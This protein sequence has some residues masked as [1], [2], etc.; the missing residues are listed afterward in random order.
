[1]LSGCSW[2]AVSALCSSSCPLLRTLDVQ[3]VEGLKD[4]QMRDLLSPPTDNRPGEWPGLG[5][6]LA[7]HTKA[8]EP[9]C[10]TGSGFNHGPYLACVLEPP[11]ASALLQR[12]QT[13]PGRCVRSALGTEGL[14][15][16]RGSRAHP[17]G[18]LLTHP[19]ASL[20][21]CSP[22]ASGPREH[23]GQC[24][25]TGSHR[26]VQGSSLPGWHPLKP[27]VTQGR[28]AASAPVAPV[29]PVGIVGA[30]YVFC[31]LSLEV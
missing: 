9:S 5:R 14:R 27:M 16:G 7:G 29:L 28:G 15:G 17:L 21:T 26:R 25:R 18:G 1:M 20:L 31:L 12:M 4:A 24:G 8:V 2:I 19:T 11:P 10:A 22:S 6:A 3:W 13:G 23:Q 30:L